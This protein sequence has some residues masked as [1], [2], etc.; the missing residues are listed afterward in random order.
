MKYLITII[1]L[2]IV[3]STVI[4]PTQVIAEDNFEFYKLGDVLKKEEVKKIISIYATGTKAY[5][6]LRTIECE[7]HFRN[8]QS[9]VV[10]KG[11]KEDSWGIA[12]INLYWNDVSKEEALDPYY[13]V[14]FM[15][16]NW[17]TI[18]WYGY[19]RSKDICNL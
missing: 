1:L 6:M 13:S 3:L 15:S 7:S 2:S 9:L 19:L 4:L 16:D 17:E 14:K 5:Q 12:Q 18:K 8:I 11:V 10:S